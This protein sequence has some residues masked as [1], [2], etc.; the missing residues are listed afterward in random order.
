[1][2]LKMIAEGRDPFKEEEESLARIAAA[3]EAAALKRSNLKMKKQMNKSSSSN[4]DIKK[5]EGS[6][7]PFE[8]EQTAMHDQQ[9]GPSSVVVGN[10]NQLDT[11][12]V[13]NTEK[14]KKNNSSKTSRVITSMIAIKKI[15]K[16]RNSACDDVER[17]DEELSSEGANQE[18]FET[19]TATTVIISAN[20]ST[21]EQITDDTMDTEA[22]IKADTTYLIAIAS[23]LP[24]DDDAAVAASVSENG[25]QPLISTTVNNVLVDIDRNIPMESDIP[26]DIDNHHS[27]TQIVGFRIEDDERRKND[28]I[29]YSNS[30]NNSYSTHFT[31]TDVR[32][33]IIKVKEHSDQNCSKE[34]SSESLKDR[35]IEEEENEKKMIANEL[36]KNSS[37]KIKKRKK[38]EEEDSVYSVTSV[39]AFDRPVPDRTERINCNMNVSSSMTRSGSSLSS[40]SSSSSSSSDPSSSS[41][42]SSSSSTSSSFPNSLP[43]PHTS[44]LSA[45]SSTSSTTLNQ[46]KIAKNKSSSLI[47]TPVPVPVPP[48]SQSGGPTWIAQ[49]TRRIHNNDVTK[50]YIL[51]HLF[52]TIYLLSLLILCVHICPKYL[53]CIFS[54]H[55]LLNKLYHFFISYFYFIFLFH[56]LIYCIF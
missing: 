52:S 39:P 16:S 12:T 37:G 53:L 40:S 17:D 35:N 18:H 1:M 15:P 30:S 24:N 8:G 34:F 50:I 19:D 47:S 42:S 46:S 54:F 9:C 7:S 14:S 10:T 38:E 49:L 32:D 51:M 3:A 28:S 25:S 43:P 2:V 5:S 56:N 55:I 13:Q 44:K 22:L 26:M 21:G 27:N 48:F 29:N 4:V 41:S 36:K 31:T 20:N 33:D 11:I 23:K 6:L 45:A